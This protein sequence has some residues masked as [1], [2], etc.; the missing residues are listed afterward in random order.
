MM[1]LE[2]IQ[3]LSDEQAEIAAADGKVPY[4][5]FDTAEINRWSTKCPIPNLGSYEPEGWERC[6]RDEWFFVDKSG[7]GRSDEP[8]MTLSQFVAAIARYD[9]LHRGYGYA[10]VEEGQFQIYIAPFK[11]LM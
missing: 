5:P 10:I 8:A 6:D 2:A 9:A 3:Q 4:V 1:S 11:S 7:F